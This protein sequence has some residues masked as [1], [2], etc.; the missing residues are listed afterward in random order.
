MFLT[1][2]AVAMTHAAPVATIRFTPENFRPSMDT[3]RLVRDTYSPL[4]L[5]RSVEHV[6][7]SATKIGNR[8]QVQ[9]CVRCFDGTQRS[10]TAESEEM[11]RALEST[12]VQGI[13]SFVM[14]C[15]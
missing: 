6:D 10:F 13:R 12:C 4:R 2:C 9:I 15:K 8:A 11:Y 7:V 1:L 5:M 3:I 14:I